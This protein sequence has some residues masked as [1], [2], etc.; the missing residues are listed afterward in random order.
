MKR[1]GIGV[2]GAGLASTGGMASPTRASTMRDAFAL[3][4]FW[5]INEMAACLWGAAFFD[6]PVRQDAR[7]AAG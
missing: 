1:A 3:W 7:R 6:S 4:L 2:M 5:I